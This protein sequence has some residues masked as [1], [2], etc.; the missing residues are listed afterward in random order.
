[1]QPIHAVSDM[2]M[3]DRYWG[4]RVQQ[5]YG[6]RSQLSAGSKLIF[7]SDAPVDTANPFI[8][9]YAAVSRKPLGC[10]PEADSWVPDQR[11]NLQEAFNA[12]SVWPAQS[13]GLGSKLGKLLPGYLADL[14]V[15]DK[16][17]FL[18]DNSELPAIKP[19]GVMVN[20]KWHFLD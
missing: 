1:M 15:L 10:A 18:I 3:A 5:S 4:D 19:S 13:L 7:G 8:G 6:W 14:I 2:Q 12:Y 16:N 17:P 11:I 20:G 9:I